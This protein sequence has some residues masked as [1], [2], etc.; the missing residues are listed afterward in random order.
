MAIVL[1]EHLQGEQARVLFVAPAFQQFPV[2]VPSLLA[3]RYR[4]WRLLLIHDGLDTGRFT[5]HVQHF[6]DPRIDYSVWP[7]RL[8]EWGHAHRAWALEHIA[9]TQMPGDFIVITNPDNYY[10]PGFLDIMLRAFQS[11]DVAVYCQHLHNG[12]G[13]GLIDTTLREG[14]LDCGA[15]MVR[16]EAA[17]SV[18]W[19]TRRYQADWDYASDLMQKYGRVA[20][21]KV[22]RVLFVHN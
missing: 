2:L 5:D 15:L 22:S 14:T 19:R 4:N 21:R 10:V 9:A 16:R 13:W 8:G 3:Q 12:C 6:D 11:N 20:F 17:L 1:P 18:G 7:E